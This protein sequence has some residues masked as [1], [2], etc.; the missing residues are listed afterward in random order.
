MPMKTAYYGFEANSMQNE[1]VLSVVPVEK[2]I[3]IRGF[4][5]DVSLSL[6]VNPPFFGAA[7]YSIALFQLW[8]SDT[9]PTGATGPATVATEFGK[10][11]F[12]SETGKEQPAN[13]GFNDTVMNGMLCVGCLNL[14]TEPKQPVNKTIVVQ[15]GSIDIE[16]PA[17]KFLVAQTTQNGIKTNFQAQLVLYYDDAPDAA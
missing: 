2:P 10:A 5:A 3:V 13:L 7:P 11:S 12:K 8:V 9:A 4:I 15:P 14:G 16:V 6:F 1:G 17:G